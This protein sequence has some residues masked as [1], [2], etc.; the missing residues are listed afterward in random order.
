MDSLLVIILGLTI[1]SFLNVL[2]DR[3][4][5]GE[6]VLWGRS[7]CD[8]CKRTLRWYELIPVLSFLLLGGKCSRCHAGLS[9]QYP[10]IEVATGVGFYLLYQ[11]IGYSLFLYVPAAVIFCSLLV[12]FMADFKYQFIPDSMVVAGILG[13]LAQLFYHRDLHGTL[14]HSLAGLATCVFFYLLW[15]FT[16][17][18][19]IGFGDVKF[20]FFLGFL[21]GYPETIL[22]LYVAFL[23]GAL[24][25]VIL[26][27]G[28][29]KSLKSKIAFGPFLVWGIVAA[30][31]FHTPLIHV[32]YMIF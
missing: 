25:G 27:L 19:G 30:M 2:I 23:T 1:G 9:L 13:V 11:S 31:V 17:K 20:S 10:L 16:K 4:P 7:H 5:K 28:N 15:L 6:N 18:K 21:L 3:L 8:Y 32:W 26:I 14:V 12:I 24:A 22:A 29:K